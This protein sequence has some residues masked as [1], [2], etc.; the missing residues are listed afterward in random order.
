MVTHRSAQRK[1]DRPAWRR[2]PTWATAVLALVLLSGCGVDYDVVINDDDT[3][4]LTYT[5]WDS[6]GLELITEETC[7]QEAMSSYSSPLPPGTQATYT[8]T[9]HG[10]DPACQISGSAIPLSELE[11]Q[12]AAWSVTHEGHEYVFSLSPSALSQTAIAD[13]AGGMTANVSVSFPGEVT[14]ANGEIDERTVTWR[15]VTGSSERLEARGYDDAFGP[16]PFFTLLAVSVALV[17][18]VLIIVGIVISRRRKR[19]ERAAMQNLMREQAPSAPS[20]P[21]PHPAYPSAAPTY[22]PQPVASPPAG[23][24]FS[25]VPPLAQSP[26]PGAPAPGQ[27][28]AAIGSYPTQAQPEEPYPQSPTPGHAHPTGSYQPT[29]YSPLGTGPNEALPERALPTYQVPLPGQAGHAPQAP[30][31]S[32]PPSSAT[33]SGPYRPPDLPAADR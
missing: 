3:V 22:Q 19:A 20:G 14:S 25:Q 21:G 15:G 4:D 28:G 31:P 11:D 27:A 16:L 13:A 33:G 26:A 9:T 10:K 32:G 5:V 30:E 18:G 12:S 7:T 2:P 6:S 29:Q 17:L 1:P 23:A 24:G 8:Y